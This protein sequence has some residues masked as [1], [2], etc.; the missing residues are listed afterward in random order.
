MRSDLARRLWLAGRTDEAE[1]QVDLAAEFY[2]SLS[3]SAEIG[4]AEK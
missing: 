4:E 3:P 1:E 2:A